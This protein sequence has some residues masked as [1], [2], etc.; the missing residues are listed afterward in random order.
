MS[1]FIPSSPDSL[2]EPDRFSFAASTTHVAH[3]AE[4][5]NAITAVDTYALMIIAD[6]GL[7]FYTEYNHI[8]NVQLTIDAL[9]FSN[10]RVDWGASSQSGPRT[11]Q[12]GINALLLSDS[13]AAAASSAAP[14]AKTPKGASTVPLEPV[15][16][17]IKYEG[18]GLPLVIAFD[19]RLISEQIEFATFHLDF[20]YPYT[21]DLRLDTH[22]LV[23]DYAQLWFDV[24]LKSDIFANLLQDLQ[25]LSTQHL[26]MYASN[27]G[28]A[29]S[30]NLVHFVSKG[31]MGYLKL[32]YPNAAT[33][34]QKVE[35]YLR[36]DVEPVP[37]TDSVLSCL[38]FLPFIK[39]FRAV[40]LSSKCKIMKDFNGVFSVQLLCKSIASS[41]AYPG[42]LLTFNMLEKTT[43]TEMGQPV[44]SEIH[45]IFGED[46]YNYVKE[47]DTTVPAAEPF[48]YASFK[49]MANDDEQTSKRAKPREDFATVGGAV[50]VPLF[51]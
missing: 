7:T 48:S 24:I 42:T 50:E 40:K 27:N 23:V 3:L 32:V 16:C 21:D 19:D 39:V 22:G 26:Y 28:D 46:D 37:T 49:R 45:D 36:D 1:L 6:S 30:P 9:L 5:L 18:E 13:C 35:I 12:L 41:S 10:F 14:R 38:N 34:L 17:Y 33:M 31:S 20:D 51:L 25:N 43:I 47:Y 2:R 4:V 29:K 11:V 8:L 15:T 44:E